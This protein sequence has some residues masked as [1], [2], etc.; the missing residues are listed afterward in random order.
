MR[1]GGYLFQTFAESLERRTLLAAVATLFDSGGFEP[2]RYAVG[3]L[4]GQDPAGPWLKTNPRPGVARVESEIT[5]D[6]AS[7]VEITRP[8]AID[9]DTRYGVVKPYT[10]A[11]GANILRIAWDMDVAPNH[12]PGIPFG[13]FMG[14]EAYD[15][16]GGVPLLIG[17][18]GVDATTGDVLYQDGNTGVLTEAGFK[19]ALGQWNHFTLEIDYAARTYTAFVD[20]DA[21]AATGFV[22]DA[23]FGFS[24]A[25]L[26]A[27]A[28]SADS[29]LTATGSAYFDNYRI[30]VFA[31]PTPPAVTAAYVSS[32]SW[33]GA[34]KE[35]MD[36]QRLGSALYGYA[37]PAGSHQLDPLPWLG[38]DRVSL[39]FS[40][41]V[42]VARDD[43]SV[44]GTSGGDDPIAAFGYDRSTKTATW[45]LGRPVQSDKVLLTLDAGPA[46]VTARNSTT[47][48]DGEWSNGQDAFPSG[49]GAAGGDFRFRIN[50]LGGDVT[51]NGRVDA[52]DLLQVRQRQD[53]LSDPHRRSRTDYAVFHDVNGDG[54]IN[55]TDLALVRRQFGSTL[56]TTEPAGATAAVESAWLDIE[57][58]RNLVL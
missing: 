47:T 52:T 39:S 38:L 51:R 33:V 13:P 46:G 8:A 41:D 1:A 58:D 11:A 34:F 23:A 14:V 26:A 7:A 57:A 20:G 32:S 3:P 19:V 54:R 55:A 53:V 25:P 4:E 10:P 21:K 36:A 42:V 56:P 16:V 18:V 49:D 31:E 27:L 24:D 9:G 17:S 2:P 40:R 15:T 44:R 50:V 30:D 28:A 5:R 22:N 48:L 35:W 12:Q 45:L 6:S 43:L 29:V 37:I